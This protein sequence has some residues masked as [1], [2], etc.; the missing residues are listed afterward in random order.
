MRMEEGALLVHIIVYFLSRTYN[1]STS[2]NIFIKIL[3]RPQ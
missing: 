2:I 1:K 3:F